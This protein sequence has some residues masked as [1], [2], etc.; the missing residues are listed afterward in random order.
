MADEKETGWKWWLRYI[1]VPLIGSGGV[2]AIVVAIIMRPV[3]NGPVLPNVGPT[4]VNTPIASPTST[5]VP[6]QM[7]KPSPTPVQTVNLEE[8]AAKPKT[9]KVPTPARTPYDPP[10][11]LQKPTITSEKPRVEFYVLGPDGKKLGEESSLQVGD[12]VTAYWNAGNLQESLYLEC[13]KSSN[14][15]TA[16]N[17]RTG[18]LVSNNSSQRA[19]VSCTLGSEDSSPYPPCKFE[20]VLFVTRQK[21]WDSLGDV[22][23]KV[24]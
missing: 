5:Q 14:W 13:R 22:T 9:H 23:F 24:R 8:P 1:V 10:K 21:T 15:L 7:P 19:T 20:C 4:P 2:I 3:N 16:V 6:N 11:A 17:G 12:S 18:K